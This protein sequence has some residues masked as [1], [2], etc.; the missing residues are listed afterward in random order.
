MK[1]TG[2]I[3]KSTGHCAFV[4]CIVGSPISFYRIESYILSLFRGSLWSASQ[5][6]HGAIEKKTCCGI[7]FGKSS[8]S[9]ANGFRC[10]TQLSTGFLRSKVGS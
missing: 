10:F 8:S 3:N 6:N 2:I 5:G 4:F 9:H 1:V 7:R